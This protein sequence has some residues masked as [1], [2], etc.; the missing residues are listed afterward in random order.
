MKI[1]IKRGW[2]DK[3]KS[4]ASYAFGDE[5]LR[6]V[7]GYLPDKI[8]LPSSENEGTIILD[9]DYVKNAPLEKILEAIIHESIHDA[10]LRNNFEKDE[11][12]E[13]NAYWKYDNIQDFIEFWREHNIS[14][15]QESERKISSGGWKE[16]LKKIVVLIIVAL[17]ILGYLITLF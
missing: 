5:V 12:T 10:I 9:A 15:K 17:M 6:L 13:L 8:D 2:K 3:A 16:I 4:V 14:R 7:D 11:I 1:S